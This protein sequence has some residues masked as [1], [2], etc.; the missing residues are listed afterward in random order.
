MNKKLISVLA[1]LLSVM[2]ASATVQYMTV[3]LQGG[4][5]YSFLL[6]D[7]PVVTYDG[8]SLVVNGSASTS[9]AIGGVKNYHFTEG[10]LTN[11]NNLSADMLRIV[12]IDESTIEV[13][14][15]ASNATV[16]LVSASGTV[17]STS[18]AAANGTARVSL[19]A[20]KGVYVL[21]VNNKSIKIIRK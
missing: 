19:P 12:S 3:E 9:Y 10:D 16:T 5:K 17:Q 14:N 7:N 21:S 18:T 13:Q 2:S 6:T 1:L 11:A 15:A 20:P 8:G 4:E